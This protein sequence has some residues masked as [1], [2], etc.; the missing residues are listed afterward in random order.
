[1]AQHQA[2]AEMLQRPELY[3]RRFVVPLQTLESLET[4]T[5]T[6]VLRVRDLCPGMVLD[7]DVRTATGSLVLARGHEV[8]FTLI[9]RLRSY[10]QR[11]GVREPFRVRVQVQ[12]A[13]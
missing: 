1:V 8:S 10:G 2:I 3:E 6:R 12:G 13:E 9:E 4:Q 7:E 5:V 11:V